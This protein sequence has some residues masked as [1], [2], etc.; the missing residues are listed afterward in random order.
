MGTQLGSQ[1]SGLPAIKGLL[2]RVD[3]KQR[4]MEVLD[5]KAN[6]FMASITSLV[7][8]NRNFANVDANSVI[9]CAMVA[10]TLDLPINQNFGFAYII[11]YSGVAQ[12]QM[13]YK[14][15]IQLAL[16][17]GQYGT[18]N[19][20][21]IFEGELIKQ[22]RLT[23]LTEFDTNAKKS[24]TIIGYAAYFKL[25][26]GFEKS[27]YM[28]IEEVRKHGKRY[29]KSFNKSDA[30]W[31]TQFDA[32]AKKTVLKRLLSGYG[33]LSVEMQTAINYDQSAVKINE[34]SEPTAEYID[35][36]PVTESETETETLFLEEKQ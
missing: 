13:G 8:A 14:G 24:D 11:P 35:N 1:N 17:T 2:A 19:A 3:V 32:M 26:S 10:A 29:S 30:P 20:T 5:K 9:G 27:L 36:L 34:E 25:N 23:G 28:S 18:I 15:F 16:R 7:A 12:F 33:I 4:F 21:E 31:Q 6:G 22:D